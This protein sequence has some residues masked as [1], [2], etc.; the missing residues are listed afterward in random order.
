MFGHVIGDWIRT[1]AAPQLDPVGEPEDDPDQFA[2]GSIETIIL[3]RRARSQAEV[4]SLILIEIHRDLLGAF[5]VTRSAASTVGAAR[6]VAVVCSSYEEAT[7]EA[8]SRI[9][10][11]LA[12]GY[13]LYRET[14]FSSGL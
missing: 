2:T 12:S 4:D 7:V 10:H 11:A 5:I 9:H 6:S 8:G 13:R 14:T 1:A 3:C